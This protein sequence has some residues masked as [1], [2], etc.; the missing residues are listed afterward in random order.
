MG[1][2]AN[3]AIEQG[4]G[5]RVWLY[6]HW[7]GYDM[8]ETLQRALKLRERWDDTPYFARIVFSTMVANGSSPTTGYGITTRMTDNEYP[9][10]VVDCTGQIV[11]IEDEPERSRAESR[12]CIGKFWTFEQF[13]ALPD[14]SWEALDKP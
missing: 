2:R 13:V 12:P 11:K 9:I 4:D 14:V 10:L 3:I 8:P 5:S 7:G 1:D 6:S